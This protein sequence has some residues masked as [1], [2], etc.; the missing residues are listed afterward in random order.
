MK[1][2]SWGGFFSFILHIGYVYFQFNRNNGSSVSAR[3][4]SR[5]LKMFRRSRKNRI[6]LGN[7][8]SFLSVSHTDTDHVRRTQAA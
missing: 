5:K 7:V 6:K 3:K 8:M 2:F 4:E 1:V